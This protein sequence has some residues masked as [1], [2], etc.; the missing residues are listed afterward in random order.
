MAKITQPKGKLVRRFGVNIYGSSKFDRLLERRSDPPGQHGGRQLRR[1]VSDYGVQ[2]LEKQKL[3]H[4]YGLLEKQFRR[5]FQ[6]ALQQKGVTGENLLIL[7]ESRLDNV[8]YRA[9]FAATRMQARQLVNHGHFLVN[10]RKVDIPSCLLRVGDVVSVKDKDSSRVLVGRC[11]EESR[12]IKGVSWLEINREQLACTLS[13]LPQR[14]EIDAQVNEQLIV[15]LY[16][17]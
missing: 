4:T 5:T 15:E 10:G 8:A 12:R 1:K 13:R 9:G 14:D 6:R 17:R 7:L 11:L 3:R 16:S 2:L